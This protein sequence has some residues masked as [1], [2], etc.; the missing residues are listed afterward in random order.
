MQTTKRKTDSKGGQEK[1][2]TGGRAQ[3]GRAQ[4][5]ELTGAQSWYPW[6][7]LARA[8]VAAS[9]ANLCQIIFGLRASRDSPPE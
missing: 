1:Q 6:I 2:H 7:A 9:V 8:S 4:Q 5:P 3:Q